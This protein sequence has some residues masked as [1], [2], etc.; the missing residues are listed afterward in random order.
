[1]IGR[2]MKRLYVYK[3][4]PT[5]SSGNLEH[6]SVTQ[7]NMLARADLLPQSQCQSCGTG[8]RNIQEGKVSHKANVNHV[9]QVGRLSKNAKS[10]LHTE[11]HTY[12]GRD[13]LILAVTA[14]DNITKP[15]CQQ[16]KHNTTCLC[17]RNAS[18]KEVLYPHPS[19]PS[20]IRATRGS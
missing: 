1:M 14:A 13:H 18:V 11:R 17:R 15:I 12:R 6:N 3:E 7:C 9:V 19:H 2:P 4:Q 16:M 20:Q 10:G 5:D 8:R